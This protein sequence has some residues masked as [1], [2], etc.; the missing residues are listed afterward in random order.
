MFWH[1][2]EE[3]GCSW[4]WRLAG[5]LHRH[6][7]LR[8]CEWVLDAGHEWH[9]IKGMLRGFWRLWPCIGVALRTG[10]AGFQPA[11][12]LPPNALATHLL[13]KPAGFRAVATRTLAGADR[14]SALWSLAFD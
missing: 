2:E 13:S 3:Q 11:L 12:A 4:E 5:F 14:I 7:G 1:R 6:R 9:L 8:Q 10:S